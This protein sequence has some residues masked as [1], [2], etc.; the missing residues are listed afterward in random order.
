MTLLPKQLSA[1]WSAATQRGHS[2]RACLGLDIGTASVKALWAER[3]KHGAARSVQ[4]VIENLPD[5][6]PEACQA[7][8]QRVLSGGPAVPSDVR[9]AMAGQDIITR[10]L[11]LPNMS[12][13]ELTGAIRFE[14][15]SYIP[16]PLSE[17]VLDKQV[18]EQIDEHKIRVLLVAGKRDAI[19]QRLD[20]VRACKVEP[21]ICDVDAFAVAN[22]YVAT[23][24]EVEPST[25]A[26]ANIGA[27]HT[28]LIV[29][30]EGQHCNFTRDLSFGSY[31]IMRVLEEQLGIRRAESEA[32]LKDPKSDQSLAA[33]QHALEMLVSEIRLSVDF[34]ETQSE[35]SIQQIIV[36][37][38]TSLVPNV[39]QFLQEHMGLPVVSWTPYDWLT[40]SGL[41]LNVS[42][43]ARLAVCTGLVVRA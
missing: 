3:T 17:V 19:N 8:L 39:M 15:E 30:R 4:Y 2:S 22:A 6:S 20:L 5:Q 38:G 13:A 28:N 24:A 29:L 7:A 12:D 33:L 16:F 41:T 31:D 34:Y 42:D 9:I 10:Y 11:T 25:V 14:G 18:I 40:Q 23:R 21:T 36:S 32:V 27:R 26:I 1:L 43:A 35:D 37:G